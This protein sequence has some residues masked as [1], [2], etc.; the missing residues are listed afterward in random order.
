MFFLCIFLSLITSFLVEG[1]AT[2]SS[3]S[4]SVSSNVDVVASKNR[5]S[6]SLAANNSPRRIVITPPI[7]LRSSSS[8]SIVG[9]SSDKSLPSSSDSIKSKKSSTDGSRLSPLYSR[10]LQSSEGDN[11][12]S[13]Y[14][15]PLLDKLQE[16]KIIEKAKEPLKK[17]SSEDLLHRNPDAAVNSDSEKRKKLRESFMARIKEEREKRKKEEAQRRKN[18][19]K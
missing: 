5:F 12:S 17:L 7:S 11:S 4:D 3:S 1:S 18:D 8:G 16:E 2:S 9:N 15:P 10:S 19:S 14:Q 13:G 6:D